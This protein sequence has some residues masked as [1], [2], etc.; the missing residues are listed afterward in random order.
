MDRNKC[1]HLVVYEYL[2]IN[3]ICIQSGGFM[4]RL[5]SQINDLTPF[6][7]SASLSYIY[8]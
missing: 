7:S 6:S 4:L 1:K 2:F 8:T 3:S 5:L